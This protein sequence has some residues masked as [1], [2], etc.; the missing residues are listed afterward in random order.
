MDGDEAQI[1]ILTNALGKDNPILGDVKSAA[2]NE[3]LRKARSSLG[4]DGS[5]PQILNDII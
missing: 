5:N 2:F 4:A 3:M 1:R